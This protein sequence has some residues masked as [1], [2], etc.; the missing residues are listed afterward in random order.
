MLV[1]VAK[2]SRFSLSQDTPSKDSHQ[3]R[4]DQSLSSARTAPI[5]TPLAQHH[6][7]DD[8]PVEEDVAPDVVQEAWHESG[9]EGGSV[10]HDDDDDEDDEDGDDLDPHDVLEEALGMLHDG[11]GAEEDGGEDDGDED[12]DEG[13]GSDSEGELQESEGGDDVE[14]VMPGPDDLESDDGEQDEEDED[15]DE[16]DDVHPISAFLAQEAEAAAGGHGDAIILG[17]EEEEG[18]EEDDQS[19]ISGDD[20]EHAEGEEGEG[21]DN[22]EDGEDGGDGDGGDDDNESMEEENEESMFPQDMEIEVAPEDMGS[23]ID[24]IVDMDG[25]M[26]EEDGEHVHGF[27][28]HPLNPW[29]MMS[30]DPEDFVVLGG[31]QHLGRAMSHRYASMAPGYGS[32]L[33]RLGDELGYG[34]RRVPRRQGAMRRHNRPMLASG[35]WTDSIDGA[36]ASQHPLLEGLVGEQ[37]IE[38]VEMTEAHLP[39]SMFPHLYVP[40]AHSHVHRAEL[41]QMFAV[42]H[43]PNRRFPP[44]TRPFFAHLQMH[45]H[46]TPAANP[47]PSSSRLAAEMRLVCGALGSVF[48]LSI[49]SEVCVI[50]GAVIDTLGAACA[51]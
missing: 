36:L 5:A 13:S 44:Q 26:E 50:I 12:E 3:S 10:A 17:G 20:D 18:E 47:S 7:G 8:H 15:D 51:S 40:E 21:E 31:M 39:H 37:S 35:N 27:P 24:A 48:A 6:L 29:D 28:R 16:D 46:P 32:L 41:D 11:N 1:I 49:I 33:M 19:D 45:A 34:Q 9:D 2:S 14:L 23:D 38:R 42:C 25:A 22:G 30:H 4:L 43:S